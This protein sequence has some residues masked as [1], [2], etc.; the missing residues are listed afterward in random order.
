MSDVIKVG[1]K[2][3]TDRRTGVGR[4][5]GGRRLADDIA[6]IDRRS[7]TRSGSSERRLL[8]RRVP[9]KFSDRRIPFK[10]T[11][12]HD[13][14]NARNVD[15]D[16]RVAGQ[17]SGYNTGAVNRG[18]IASAPV[19]RRAARPAANAAS[20]GLLK[21]FAKKAAIVGLGAAA[22]GLYK[23]VKASTIGGDGNR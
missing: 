4:R 8:E 14:G 16:L 9:D 1:K 12:E 6:D 5:E 13:F 21:G 10:R 22:Y 19:V 20:R 23:E 17:P 3:L 7:T 15:R 2:A 11:V 18:R